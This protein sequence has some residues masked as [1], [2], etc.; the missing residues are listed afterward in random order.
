MTED[1]RAPVEVLPVGV[2]RGGRTGE[3][4]DHGGG[5]VARIALDPQRYRPDALAGL[6]D[7]SPVEVV[8]HFH[9]AAAADEQAGSRHP[10]RAERLAAG[11]RLRPAREGPAQ[12]AGR[13]DLPGTGGGG[14]DGDGRGTGR[15]GRLPVLDLEPYLAEFGPRGPVR[16]PAWS[17]ALMGEYVSPVQP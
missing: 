1:W 12:P 9:L 13:H 3:A 5:V 14:A 6:G 11:R 7:F 4:D 10:P 8:F 17:H 16:Q 2:V 15:A